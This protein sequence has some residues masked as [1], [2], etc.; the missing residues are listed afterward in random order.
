MRSGPESR[1]NPA[2]IPFEDQQRGIG[3]LY[4]VLLGAAR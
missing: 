3:G 4:V 1:W 2:Q